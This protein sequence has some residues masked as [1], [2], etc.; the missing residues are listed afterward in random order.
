[1][2]SHDR[3]TMTQRVLRLGMRIVAPPT[4]G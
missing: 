1:M 4:R 3:F 2:A